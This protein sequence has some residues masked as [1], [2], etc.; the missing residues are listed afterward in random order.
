MQLNLLNNAPEIEFIS[1]VSA[2][3]RK[4]SFPFHTRKS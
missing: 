1:D 3:F 4:I 2:G